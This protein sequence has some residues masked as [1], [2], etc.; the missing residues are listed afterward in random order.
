MHLNWKYV[1]VPIQNKPNQS[2]RS[3]IYM[4][5][6]FYMQMDGNLVTTIEMGN[7]FYAL[8]LK[9]LSWIKI[10]LRNKSPEKITKTT[11]K[12]T[13]MTRRNQNRRKKTMTKTTMPILW[14][15]EPRKSNN[16]NVQPIALV[17]VLPKSAPKFSIPFGFSDIVLI[18]I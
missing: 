17:F 2:V 5:S 15:E 18:T 4:W 9:K 12:T 10:I 8:F 16:I 7:S 11:K 3:I 13:T 1:L 6:V 14:T